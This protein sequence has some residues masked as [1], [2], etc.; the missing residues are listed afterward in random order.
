MTRQPL[1]GLLIVFSSSALIADDWRQFRGTQ[2]SSVAAEAKLPTTW[3]IKDGTNVA[4]SAELPGRGPSSPILVAGKVIVTASSGAAQDRLHVLCFDAASGK[5]LWHRQ[6][7]ATGRCFTHP[8][9]ANAANSPAS[10]GERVYAFYSSNDLI[11]LD[12]E[13]RLQ[14]YRGLAFDYPK[15]GNDAGMSSSPLVIGDTVIA[16]VESQG[17]SFVTGL[18]AVTGETRWLTRRGTDANWSSPVE[19]RGGEKSLALIQAAKGLTAVEPA[20]GKEVWKYEHACDVISSASV[21]DGQI[22][23]PSQG[24][25]VL[26]TAADSQGAS[27]VWSENKLAPGA[28]SPVVHN[29]RIYTVDRAPVLTCANLTNGKTLWQQRLKGSFWATPVLAGDHLYCL[30][31]EGDC[32]VVKLGKNKA[33]LAATNAFGEPLQASPAVVDNAMYVRSDKHLWKISETK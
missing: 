19:L 29:G 4:W 13:G 2:Q 18:N 23:L 14:W 7:W 21:V 6:F 22:V 28:A 17:D 30:S 10:D 26:N 20:T 31:F 9:S 3:N 11:C 8:Q 1:I 27:F 15:A 32:Q 5:Q 25:T 33:E 16:Q 12:L 24:I